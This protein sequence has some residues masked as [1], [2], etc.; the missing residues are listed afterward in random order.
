MQNHGKKK[1]I[2]A[3]TLW[4]FYIICRISE[5]FRCRF[6]VSLNNA[7]LQ[8]YMP[9]ASMWHR[10]YSWTFCALGRSSE[11]ISEALLAPVYHHRTSM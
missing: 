2:R 9:P 5:L 4:I 3:D 10:I 6:E 11:K 8:H 7:T 1:R